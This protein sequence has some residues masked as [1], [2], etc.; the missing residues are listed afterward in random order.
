[1]TRNRK[2]CMGALVKPPHP[3]DPTDLSTSVLFLFSDMI[4]YM[5]GIILRDP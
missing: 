3:P 4:V 2:H 5:E 1:M